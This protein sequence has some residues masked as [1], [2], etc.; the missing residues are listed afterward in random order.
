MAKKPKMFK[1]RKRK[2]RLVS[3]IVNRMKSNY[4]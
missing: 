4:V 2:S 3:K 1:K